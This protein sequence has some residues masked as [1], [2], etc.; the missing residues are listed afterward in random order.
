MG[1]CG[2]SYIDNEIQKANSISELAYVM[3][4][5]KE[6]LGNEKA[7]IQAHIANQLKEVTLIDI[8]ALSADD[9]EK[10]I[11]YLD[12]LSECYGDII[13]ILSNNQA[14]PLNETKEHLHSI[15][16]NYFVSYDDTETYK[17]DFET[18][19]QFALNHNNNN[20]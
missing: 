10:R 6:N 5:K 3:Q 9:L 11:P 14:L 20:N 16:K 7:E 1:C 18:F 17:S 15:L 2:S 12:K 8:S 19:K 4:T 13:D